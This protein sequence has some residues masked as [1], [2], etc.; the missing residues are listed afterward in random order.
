MMKHEY[1]KMPHSLDEVMEPGYYCL[2][3]SSENGNAPIFDAELTRMANEYNF[4]RYKN[5]EN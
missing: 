4:M 5:G 2:D 3:G 1:K